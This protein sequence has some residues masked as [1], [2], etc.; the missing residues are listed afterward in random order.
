[1][2]PLRPVQPRLRLLV[3]SLALLPL[4]GSCGGPV[5]LDGALGHIPVYSPASLTEPMM[6]ASAST[7]L[8]SCGAL[9]SSM[10]PSCPSSNSLST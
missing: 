7:I 8:P 4:A 2:T 9:L 1:M 3:A 5:T 10:K 6:M